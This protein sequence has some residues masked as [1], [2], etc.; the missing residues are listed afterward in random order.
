MILTITKLTIASIIQNICAVTAYAVCAY[1]YARVCIH[2]C[3]L[4]D[5]IP[6]DLLSESLS[7]ARLQCLQSHRS[8]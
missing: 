1:L 7:G 8:D 2:V 6:C 4:P 3:H 5:P